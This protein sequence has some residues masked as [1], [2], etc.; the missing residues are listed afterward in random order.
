MC[1]ALEEIKAIKTCLL[2]AGIMLAPNPAHRLSLELEVI[3]E[4]LFDAGI[5]SVE[6]FQ[7]L[8]RQ[9]KSIAHFVHGMDIEAMHTRLQA[10]TLKRIG[11]PVKSLLP[12]VPAGFC[13][14]AAIY[15]CGGNNGRGSLTAC[16]FFDPRFGDWQ[17]LPPMSTARTETICAMV[18]GCLC[19]VGGT[20]CPAAETPVYLTSA[21]YF[22][23]TI[24]EWVVLPPMKTARRAAAS[25]VIAHKL[26]ICGGAVESDDSWHSLNTVEMLD[27]A[28]FTWESSQAMQFARHSAACGVIAGRLYVAGGSG[29]FPLKTAERLDPTTNTWHQLPSMHKRRENPVACVHGWNLCV[30]G[31]RV[32]YETSSDTFFDSGWSELH[33]VEVFSTLSQSW[34]V[35]PSM[36]ASCYDDMGSMSGV[37]CGRLYVFGASMDKMNRRL[38][39]YCCQV[40]DPETGAWEDLP[41]PPGNPVRAQSAQISGSF[42]ICGGFCAGHARYGKEEA[43]NYATCFD[44]Q[45]GTWNILPTMLSKRAN[46]MLHD[47]V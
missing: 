3:K 39:G 12:T 10:D 43:L 21:E 44:A 2:D 22:D 23:L 20:T 15:A 7:T 13:S 28:S 19:V 45:Q 27:M 35:L 30:C 1:T 8:V 40:F 24:G 4:Y 38:P 42:Y 16:E 29:I 18:A 36:P 5:V 32:P 46:S 26:Y 11:F 33:S 41:P 6:K 25:A 34:E 47:I 37:A 14:A 17:C 31:G 9:H